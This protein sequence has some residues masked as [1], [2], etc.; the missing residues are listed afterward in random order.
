VDGSD[1]LAVRDVTRRLRAR[2]EREHEPAIMDV[3]SFRFRGHSVIDP[4][5]YRNVDEVK[6]GRV[7][8]DPL[9]HFARR[10]LDAKIADDNDIRDTADKVEHEVQEAIDFADQSRPP[11]MADLYN[12][13][14]ASE[15]PNTISE[16]EQEMFENRLENEGKR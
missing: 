7:E 2:A 11:A 8:H 4:D 15:V 3:V 1:V 9:T 16:A 10:L 12:Y 13:M 6:R 14:Y 5:R